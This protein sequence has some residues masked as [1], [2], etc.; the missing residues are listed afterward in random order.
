[1]TE[2]NTISQHL[3]N[4]NLFSGVLNG[5]LAHVE[6]LSR[7]NSN[8]QKELKKTRPDFNICKNLSDE[9]IQAKKAD[10]AL[11]DQLKKWKNI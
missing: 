11:M 7:I 10:I 3:N 4:L 6:R 8:L 9:I 2:K 5:S 1:M